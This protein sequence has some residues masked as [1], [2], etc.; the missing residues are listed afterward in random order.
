[1][2][3]KSIVTRESSTPSKAL[4]RKPTKQPYPYCKSQATDITLI[5]N[6][7]SI[8]TS[9]SSNNRQIISLTLQFLLLT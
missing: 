1:M 4:V 5:K 7:I 3:T 9:K 6:E 2:K 8:N